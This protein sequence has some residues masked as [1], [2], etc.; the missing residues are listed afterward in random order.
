MVQA[1]QLAVHSRQLSRTGALLPD[2]RLLG[3][4]VLL[5]DGE[6]VVTGPAAQ[7]HCLALL[8]LLAGHAHGLPRDRAVDF[9]WQDCAITVGRHRL[10]VALHV[11]RKRLGEGMITASGDA[12]SL[13]PARWRID[14][15]SF[16]A[17]VA[18]GRFTSALDRYRAPLLDGF[19]M[20][21]AAGFEHWLERWR[22][23]LARRHLAVLSS[24]AGEAELAGDM[25]SCIAYRR[26]LA[27]HD[28]C[29]GADTVALMRSLNAAGRSDEAIRCARAYT[30]LLHEE[31]GLGPDPAVVSVEA[32]IRT[33]PHEPPP[34][35]R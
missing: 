10:S 17:D 12:L 6:V 25:E 35:M 7:R 9:L 13:A 24:L 2:L 23:R 32:F 16:E 18:A 31:Y 27:T 11:I 8:A 21:H 26:E 30:L 33:L 20:R 29:S 1:R 15:W 34:H 22:D 14:A 28:P 3:S 19:F 5:D 4:P